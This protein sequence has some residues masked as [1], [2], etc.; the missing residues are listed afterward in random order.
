MIAA[1]NTSIH[2]TPASL[3]AFKAKAKEALTAPAGIVTMTD[4]V[5]ILTHSPLCI[6]FFFCPFSFFYSF[7]Y[8]FQHRLLELWWNH[9][10]AIM[11]DVIARGLAPLHRKDGCTAPPRECNG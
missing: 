8:L 4:E 5:I 10:P 2:A 7:S 9:S 6:I 11:H 1:E 3:E